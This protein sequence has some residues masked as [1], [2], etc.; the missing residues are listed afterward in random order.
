MCLLCFRRLRF[1]SGVSTPQKD[2]FKLDLTFTGQGKDYSR[3]IGFAVAIV[4]I[5]FILMLM[6]SNLAAH[7]LPMNDDYLQVLVPAAPD[8]KEP[9]AL[10]TLDQQ[11]TD[12]TIAITGTVANRTD[13]PIVGLEAVIDAQDIAGNP[14]TVAVAVTPSEVPAKGTATFQ[15]TVTLQQKPSGYSL[16]FRLADGPTIPHRDDRAI[17]AAGAGPSGN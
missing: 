9:L 1:D 11:L 6:T 15:A 17:T 8:G 14:K 13:Y 10:K 3:P 16:Q 2:D 5:T 12:S 7:I 4:G